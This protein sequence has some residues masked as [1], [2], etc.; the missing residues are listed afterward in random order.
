MARVSSFSQGLKHPSERAEAPHLG[1]A[2]LANDHPLGADH[3]FRFAS[4]IA[5]SSSS[6]AKLMQLSA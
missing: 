3:L 5:R 2:S 6:S 4:S 1:N